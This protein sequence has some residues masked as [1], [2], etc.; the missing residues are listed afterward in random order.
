MTTERNLTFKENPWFVNLLNEIWIVSEGS[1]STIFLNQI[2]VHWTDIQ[3]FLHITAVNITKQCNVRSIAY[4]LPVSPSVLQYLDWIFDWTG[5]LFLL[6]QRLGCLWER[7]NSNARVFNVIA[8]NL[9]LFFCLEFNNRL[10]VHILCVQ[11]SHVG[12]MHAGVVS[13]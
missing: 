2:T 4:D 1:Y 11:I 8:K 6:Y 9:L 13:W 10:L 7:T 5:Y 3:H 12:P